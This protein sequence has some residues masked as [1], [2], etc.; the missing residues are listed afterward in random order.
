MIEQVCIKKNEK[1]GVYGFILFKDGDWVSTVVDDQLYYILDT[2]TLRK[3]LYFGKCKDERETWLPLLE[4]AYAKIH[5]DYESLN[6]GLPS[7]G[8]EELTGGVALILFTNVILDVGKVWKVEMQRVNK[9]TL[10]GCMIMRA[11]P[12]QSA[13]VS[14]LAMP[15]FPEN[16]CC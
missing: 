10:M 6:G 7:E 9:E 1:V 13:T 16:C 15:Q 12:S 8:N 14:C 3:S 4:K 11:D 2:D 5:G